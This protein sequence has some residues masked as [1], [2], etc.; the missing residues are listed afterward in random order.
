MEYKKKCAR[1]AE[2]KDTEGFCF[3]SKRKDGLNPICRSCCHY[4]YLGN[5]KRTIDFANAQFK[6][7]D[8]GMFGKYWSMV[9][10]CKYPSQIN[11]KYYGGKGI[12][13]EWKS[14]AEFRE[15]MY[16]SY[17][18]H[19]SKHGRKDTTIDRIDSDLNY[20]RENCRW[21][22]MKEQNAPGNK[23]KLSTTNH[24]KYSGN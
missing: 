12:R 21:A 19:V 7:R 22:T 9:R 11:Y 18:E 16:D 4:Y 20:C 3:S 2:E 23:K 8:D 24:C 17:M 1:C 10:R 13:V 15:D 14:Y 5:K 6:N